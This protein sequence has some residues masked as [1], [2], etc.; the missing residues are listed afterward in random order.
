MAR[1]TKEEA[2]KTRNDILDSAAKIFS[3]R[4]VHRTSLEDIAKDA[5]VTRGAI[6]WHFKNKAEIFDALHDDLYTPL[7]EIITS[8]LN[9]EADAP[10]QQLQN[11]CVQMLLDIDQ[12]QR[13]RQ[14]MTLFFTKCNYSG[15]LEP[16]HEE[17]QKRKTASIKLFAQFFVQAQEKGLICKEKDPEVLSL[18]VCCYIKGIIVEYLM[19]PQRFDMKKQAEGLVL[20]LFEG[21]NH[22]T[23]K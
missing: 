22:T 4:G 5:Q 15:D 16:Y 20:T 12:D 3:E 1:K 7:S 8:N 18:S 17:H 23:Q 10:L 2:Q 13:K 9:Q 14:T 19:N 6:Y 21:I 11:M